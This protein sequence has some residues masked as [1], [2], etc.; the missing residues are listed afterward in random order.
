MY[1][2]LGLQ[3]QANTVDSGPVTGPIQNRSITHVIAFLLINYLIRAFYAGKYGCA[4][5]L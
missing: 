1:L 3:S 4:I 2:T 5:L